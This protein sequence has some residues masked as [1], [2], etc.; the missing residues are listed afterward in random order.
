MADRILSIVIPT[1]N[2]ARTLDALLRTLARPETP[3]G[4]RREIIAGY[5][6]SRD[7]TL[8]VLR[9]HGVRVVHSTTIGA[10]PARNAAA[11]VARGELFWFIDS[12]AHPVD[13]DFLLRLIAAARRA[14]RFGVIGGPIML[15]PE[16]RWNPVAIADHFACWFNWTE[17][18]WSGRSRLFQPSVS[19]AIP[20]AAFER[21]GGFDESVR[22]LQDFEIQTRLMRAGYPVYFIRSLTVYHAPR[23]SLWRTCRHSWYWG[24]P[25]REIYLRTARGYPL[26]YPV[27]SRRFALN[28][29][30]LFARRMRLV[31]AAAWN[32]SPGLTCFCLPF[33]ATTVLAWTL[34]VAFGDGR[35][36]QHVAAPV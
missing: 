35:P 25:F 4:W 34:G 20:R 23:S 32:V 30:G 33:L 28:V 1:R 5:Q 3:P 26:R 31:L 24:G 15:P 2:Q 21:V 8:A 9:R 18:R 7:D 17:R 27:D 10:G 6:D 16:H 22:V 11:A 19:I 14:R 13:R 29:P 36:G 12:D